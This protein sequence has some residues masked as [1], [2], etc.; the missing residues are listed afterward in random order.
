MK[1]RFSQRQVIGFLRETA[2]SPRGAGVLRKC[3]ERPAPITVQRIEG[4]REQSHAGFASQFA[5][6]PG[7][8]APFHP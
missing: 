1:K 2:R 4:R 5:A 3:G 7:T 8:G 6:A